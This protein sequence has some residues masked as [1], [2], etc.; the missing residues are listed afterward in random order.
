MF[1]QGLAYVDFLDKE[2]LEAAIKKNK[3]KLLSKKVSIAHSDPSKSKKNREAG[4]SSKGQGMFC[5]C[6]HTFVLW[7]I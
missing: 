5:G 6:Y 7:L 1:L 4:T 2:H 3:Q